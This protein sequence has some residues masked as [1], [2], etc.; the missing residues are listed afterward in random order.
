MIVQIVTSLALVCFAFLWKNKTRY[1]TF[2]ASVLTMIFASAFCLYAHAW[3]S[4]YESSYS[5]LWDSTRSGDVSLSINSNLDIYVRILPFFIIS[6]VALVNNLFFRYET[7][8]KNLAVFVILNFISLVMIITS[9]NFIQLIT[10]VFIIDMI[11][12]FLIRD[13]N[14]GRRYALYNLTADM[15]LFLAFAVLRGNML[16]LNLSAL[17]ESV[18]PFHNFVAVVILLSLCIKFGF[19]IFHSF[20][21][22][23]KSA[24]F[25]RFFLVFYL[26]S[27][28]TALILSTK[29]MPILNQLEHFSL[30]INIIVALNLIWGTIGVAFI[31]NLKEKT[32]YLNMM[33]F[34][35][36][37]KLLTD[38]DFVWT[39]IF[40]YIIIVAFLFNLSLYYVHYYISRENNV[41]TVNKLK[42][43]N[44]I[45]LYMIVA[46][47]LAVWAM[48]SMLLFTF[49]DGNLSFV[50]WF[51][52]LFSFAG[53][54]VFIPSFQNDNLITDFR[55]DYDHRPLWIF[56][57][58]L[59]VTTV[60]IFRQNLCFYATLPAL[61]SFL[62]FFILS[63]IQFIFKTDTLWLKLQQADV[64]QNIYDKILARPIHSI[65]KSLTLFVDFMFFE[66][67]LI[68]I[69]NTLSGLAVRIFRR[70]SRANI[71]CY[72]ISVLITIILLF[73]FLIRGN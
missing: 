64:F 33:L 18:I 21:L 73:L 14:A 20:L 69:I 40:S 46:V 6:L 53:A 34:A 3:Q 29:L 2:L 72:V 15:G 50:I 70:I 42:Y 38:S 57:T 7:R 11:S 39:E 1:D 55:A 47:W 62:I 37:F 10:F 41:L 35:I 24:K 8:K 22:D 31:N 43:I 25:H 51:I 17:G 65:G 13:I 59:I 26:S 60:I 9:Q 36:I 63:P 58:I 19:F 48:M 54:H 28:M 12:Q 45:P 5:I 61:T 27:P 71:L 49:A 56:A 44:P 32:V 66:K 30:L 4:G 68:L 23:L 67:T 16:N 52:I